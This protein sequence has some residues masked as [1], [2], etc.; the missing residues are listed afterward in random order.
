MR[1]DTIF[2]EI[3]DQAWPEDAARY[4]AGD[5]GFTEL[6]EALSDDLYRLCIEFGVEFN[7]FKHRVLDEVLNRSRLHAGD[8]NVDR[9][10]H[11]SAL[12]SPAQDNLPMLVFALELMRDDGNEF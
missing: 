1:F 9:G 12:L 6:A 5:P 2:R 7:A 4:H 3:L 10:E 11:P 8:E